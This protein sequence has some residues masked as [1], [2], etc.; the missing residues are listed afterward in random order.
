[1]I[2]IDTDEVIIPRN[3]SNYS[4]LIQELDRQRDVPGVP[5]FSYVFLNIYYLL[6]FEPDTSR[7]S[8]LR[9]IRHRQRVRPKSWGYAPKSIVDPRQCSVLFNHYCARYLVR[10]TSKKLKRNYLVPFSTASSHHYRYC[11][12]F[13]LYTCD[14][15]FKEK[16]PDDV[17][18]QYQTLIDARVRK[19]LR[20]RSILR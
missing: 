6:D 4:L 12:R 15:L 10:P 19:V 3:I 8:Y 9:T 20:Q 16:T 7:P 5:A 1:M 13:Y 18:L 17:M 11:G 2:V 14:M